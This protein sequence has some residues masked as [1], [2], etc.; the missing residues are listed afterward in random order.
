M[1]EGT[2]AL[3]VRSSFA[4]A[5]RLR[6][7]EGNCERLHG[8]NWLVEVTVESRELGP[9]GMAVDFRAIKAALHEVLARLDHGYLNDVPPFDAQN[10]TSENIA[11]FISEEME[12]R[13]PPPPR[14]SRVTVWESEDARAEYSRRA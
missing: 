2:Y 7:Y 8:H 4:A 13:I 12:K 3:T 1:S 14:V 10:P 11:R 5:H 9:L 6:E